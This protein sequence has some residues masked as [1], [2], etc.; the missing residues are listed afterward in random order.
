[1]RDDRIASAEVTNGD[2]LVFSHIWLTPRASFRSSD[3][4]AAALIGA[5]DGEMLRLTS[6]SILEPNFNVSGETVSIFE[7][8]GSGGALG[9]TETQPPT[10]LPRQSLTGPVG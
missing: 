6:T 3:R 7:T 9:A 1:M 2:L 8:V 5:A 4:R 10:A